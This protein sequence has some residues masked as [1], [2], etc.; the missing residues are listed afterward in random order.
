MKGVLA[1]ASARPWEWSPC[2]ARPV[3]P[4]I[5]VAVLLLVTNGPSVVAHSGGL[6][7]DGCHYNRST[8][9]RHCHRQ[10]ATTTGT[11]TPAPTVGA[12]SSVT[13]TQGSYEELAKALLEALLARAEPSE[14]RLVDRL[15]AELEADPHA[16]E[17]LVQVLLG[18]AIPVK[19]AAAA[20][21]APAPAAEP[22][23]ATTSVAG[24]IGTVRPTTDFL[25]APFAW[26]ESP[27]TCC[28]WRG[29][30]VRT[31]LLACY[32][33]LQDSDPYDPQDYPHG[34]DLKEVAIA[35]L[36][37][38]WSPYELKEFGSTDE[39]EIEHVVALEEAHRSGLC[40]QSRLVRRLFANDSRNIALV[41]KDLNRPDAA[42]DASDWM[43]PYNGCWWA[44]R[45][46]EVKTRWNLSVDYH[47]AQALES[48]LTGCTADDMF[49]QRRSE[50]E[51]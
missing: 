50:V 20:E 45:V 28:T 27:P 46:V 11:S 33:E 39:A 51:R 31:R 3:G 15:V 8:G 32:D 9:V 6:A 21:E 26:K 47:E 7:A 22:E 34:S 41:S 18:D 43:P 42:S 16:R 23:H 30:S 36:G 35:E 40:L 24:A 38:V 14:E 17:R 29:L 44:Q 13:T 12:R 10:P 4:V 2:R 25:T 48:L 5:L 19:H 37:G 49:L 1:D